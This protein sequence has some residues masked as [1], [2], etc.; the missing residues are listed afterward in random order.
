M[1]KP[2]RTV[3]SPPPPLGGDLAAE[4]VVVGLY[5]RVSTDRQ[6]NE[7]D[8]L[9]EQESELRKYCDYRN[10]R[11]HKLYIERGKSGGNTN[12]PEYK[13]IIRDIEA[14]KINAVVVKKIDRLSRSLLDFEALMVLLESNGVDFI[15]LREQFDTTTA[16]GKA[17]LRIT[18]IFAQLEREQTSERIKDV[19]AYRAKQGMYNGGVRP[20]GYDCLSSELI[21]HKQERKVIEFIF[22]TFLQ[23]ESTTRT[24]ELCNSAGF[25]LRNGQLWDGRQTHK[26]LTR[27]V[28]KGDVKW[29]D[30]YYKGIHQPLI[31]DTKWDRVQTV[32]NSRKVDTPRTQ[33]KGL[34]TGVLRCG[35]CHNFWLPNYTTK[36]S[37]K[38]YYYYRCQSTFNQLSQN[39]K[40]KYISLDT[41][42]IEV[43]AHL[44]ACTTDHYFELLQQKM[45]RHNSQIQAKAHTATVELNRL[46]AK[47]EATQQK[48]EKYL[49][50]LISGAS[51]SSSEREKINR[52][53]TEYELEEKQLEADIWRQTMAISDATD[54]VLNIQPFKEMMIKFKLNHDGFAEKDWKKWFTQ[55]IQSIDYQDGDYQVTFKALK[56]L[57]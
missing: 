3:Q 57:T 31:T 24:A 10:F 14:K 21:P 15:S 51:F 32:F 4:S 19:F 48:R 47:K 33:I 27:Q 52:R 22:D 18:L 42:H 36:K 13:A 1:K 12:R 2:S 46:T 9:E 54:L 6:A 20:F 11:I 34:L 39:C 37:G 55:H 41:A 17:M 43:Q 35:R 38:K 49:D 16:I 5:L 7:G 30:Q 29:N 28:Y 45:D 23:T 25:R 26:I 40:G 8:S 50:S 53:I 56:T 44:L